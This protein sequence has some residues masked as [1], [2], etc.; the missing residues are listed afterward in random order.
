MRINLPPV[1]LDIR[2]L[3]V[4]PPL[5]DTSPAD[6]NASSS[7]S[8]A[9]VAYQ[10]DRVP[11]KR[12]DPGAVDVILSLDHS[13]PLALESDPKFRDDS[14]HATHMAPRQ[15]LEFS[16]N[17]YAAGLISFEDYEALAFQP[18]LHPDFNKTIG[19]LTGEKAAPDRP[20]DFVLEWG[21]RLDYARR[22]YPANSREVRQ[23]QRILETLQSFPTRTDIFTGESYE[24]S[25]DSF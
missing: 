11:D 15:M 6:Q 13:E 14:I 5:E 1:P 24:I 8:R 23:A 22:Y 2:H 19:A 4:G 12:H 18:E 25:A 10:D 21:K 9:L 17:L 7:K 16:E 3:D 20:R